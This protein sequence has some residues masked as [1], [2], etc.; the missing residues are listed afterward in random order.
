MKQLVEP[1]NL[2]SNYKLIE[3]NVVNI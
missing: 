1:I 3:E 2:N